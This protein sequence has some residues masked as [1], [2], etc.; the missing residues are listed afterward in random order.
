VSSIRSDREIYAVIQKYLEAADEP[1][2]CVDLIDIPEVFRVA[3]EEF[4]DDKRIATNKLS[5][6]LGFMWRRGLLTRYPTTGAGAQMARYAYVWVPQDTG[7]AAKPELPPVRSKTG[8]VVQE[9]E[10]GIMIE[11]D[12]FYVFVRPKP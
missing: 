9:Q 8:L 1:K 3:T 10:D 11:F 7:R 6:T 12:K 2:T 5:D 4:G